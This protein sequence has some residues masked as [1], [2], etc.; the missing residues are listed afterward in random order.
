M[1]KVTANLTTKEQFE[2]A[3]YH[4]C[5]SL[6]GYS[7]IL[8]SVCAVFAFFYT[9][10]KV[11]TFTSLVLLFCAFL[12]IVIKPVT[13]YFQAKAKAQQENALGPI[14]YEFDNSQFEARQGEKSMTVP[15]GS[16]YK[17]K[18]TRHAVLIYTEKRH[19]LILPKSDIGK[20]YGEIR[21]IMKQRARNAS[22][23]F[24]K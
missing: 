6:A 20:E 8:I 18:E 9:F 7:G 15:Y 17:I 12:F 4:T 22:V 14:V 19:A 1:I 21:R 3:M 5:T 24:H 13:L 16:I 23:R 11:D 2:F 10:G